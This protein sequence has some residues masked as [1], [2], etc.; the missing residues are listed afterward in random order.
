M[1]KDEII[2]ALFSKI[3]QTRDQL[4]TI[5]VALDDDDLV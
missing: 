3:S 4:A 2:Y 1:G 5:G